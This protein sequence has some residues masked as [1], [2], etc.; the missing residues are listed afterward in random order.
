MSNHAVTCMAGLPY[1]LPQ[2]RLWCKII[3]MGRKPIGRKA[4]TRTEIQK[5]WRHKKKAADQIARMEA[6][7][8]LAAAL[9]AFSRLS[10]EDRKMFFAEVRRASPKGN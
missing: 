4:L 7:P 8:L 10:P 6:A 3:C 5:R 2:L 1:G 9:R